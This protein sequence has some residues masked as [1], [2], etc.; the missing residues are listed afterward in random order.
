MP[1]NCPVD[2]SL[3]P[4]CHQGVHI[5]HSATCIYSASRNSNGTGRTIH[6]AIYCTPSWKKGPPR[7]DCVFVNNNSN[8]PGFKS[9][10]VGQLL[11]LFSIKSP[12]GSRVPD[13]PCA[14]VQ[15]F[16]AVGEQ[17][18]DLSGMWMV[19]PEVDPR[20]KQRA[21]DVIHLGSIVR[22]AHLVPIYGEEHVPHDLH[23]GDVLNSFKGFYVNK[24]SDYHAFHLAF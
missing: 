21:M 13:T 2:I 23:A 6:Q 19:K 20:T 14:L 7:Y 1:A 5:F 9:L 3:C 8:L 4:P 16:T 17:P 22:P 15:W 11:L 18:C 10:W 12:R 24:F